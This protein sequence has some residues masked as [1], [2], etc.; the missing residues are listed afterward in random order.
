MQS[1]DFQDFM[2]FYYIAL[3]HI[4]AILCLTAEHAHAQAELFRLEGLFHRALND[5]EAANRAF[6]TS[7]ALWPQLAAGWLSWGDFCDSRVSSLD[8]SYSWN[9]LMYSLKVKPVILEANGEQ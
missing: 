8:M 1:W 4:I 7:L 9:Q 3:L 5:P 6:S 2:Q